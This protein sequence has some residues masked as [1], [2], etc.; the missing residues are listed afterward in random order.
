MFVFLLEEWEREQI[1][2]FTSVVSLGT[3]PSISAQ[4]S[5][6]I[7]HVLGGIKFYPMGCMVLISPVRCGQTCHVSGLSENS[8]KF[9]AFFPVNLILT[10]VSS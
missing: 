6:N 9:I 10:Q 7:F 3:V 4:C 1:T 5:I 8:A 2:Q